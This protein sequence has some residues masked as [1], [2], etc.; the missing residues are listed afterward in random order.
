[1]GLTV[2]FY[3]ES[4]KG[5]EINLPINVYLSFDGLRFKYYS[6]YRIDLKKW[7]IDNV[8][9]DN[10]IKSAGSNNNINVTISI[11]ITCVKGRK[12]EL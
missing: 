4:R 2:N 12:S 6:G 3:L 8:K 1:M 11:K 5:N 9:P 10:L 7:D